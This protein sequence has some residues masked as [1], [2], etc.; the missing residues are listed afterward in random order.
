MSVVLLSCLRWCASFARWWFSRLLLGRLLSLY[1]VKFIERHILGRDCLVWLFQ[2]G[3]A[4][5][6]GNMGRLN[7]RGRA[8]YS[9]LT[10]GSAIWR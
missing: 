10:L 6:L 4:N 7:E 2:L 5:L 1:D 8:G 3:C 9:A